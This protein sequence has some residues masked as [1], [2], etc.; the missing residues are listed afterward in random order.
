MAVT[1]QCQVGLCKAVSDLTVAD[2]P[3]RDGVAAEADLGVLMIVLGCQLLLA[4][5]EVRPVLPHTVQNDGVLAGDRNLGLS[6]PD[7]LDQPH[8]PGFQT[9]P[10]LHPGQQHAS[11]FVQ[12]GSNHTVATFRG[13]TAAIDLA[14]LIASRCEPEICANAA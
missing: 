3:D 8:T 1:T 13:S 9:R 14:R 10:S 12:T 5:S 11:G 7:G 4:C 6:E 2:R